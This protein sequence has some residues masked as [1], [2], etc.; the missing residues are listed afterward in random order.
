MYGASYVHSDLLCIVGILQCT[1]VNKSNCC[2]FKCHYKMANPHGSVTENILCVVQRNGR[3]TPRQ[4][5]QNTRV[6][7]LCA[8]PSN[9][10]GA[11]CILSESPLSCTNFDQSDQQT[12]WPVGLLVN[13][14][15]T[16]VSQVKPNLT[17][18]HICTIPSGECG[19]H[20]I[21]SEG[22]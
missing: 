21:L 16:K 2:E 5:E 6:V 9:E 13:Q 1:I 3:T 11:D 15:H 14:A 20:R 22:P 17:W 10:C 18:V 7:Q 19:T 8:V 12:L 4:A